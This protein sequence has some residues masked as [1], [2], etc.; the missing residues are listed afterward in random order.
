MRWMEGGRGKKGPLDRRT[1][2]LAVIWSQ[3][4]D[5]KERNHK[6]EDRHG[7]RKELLWSTW[8]GREAQTSSGGQQV[9]SLPR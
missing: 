2:G 9:G 5:G 7:L 8:H 6:G 1:L 3:V 4:E